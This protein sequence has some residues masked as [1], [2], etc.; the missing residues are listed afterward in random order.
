MATFD[1]LVREFLLK[2]KVALHAPRWRSTAHSDYAEAAMLVASHDSR[3]MRG[4]IVLAAH[5]VRQ[6]PKYCLSLI[7]RNERVLALDV[8]PARIHRNLLPRAKVGGTHW[9]QWPAMEAVADP[10]ERPFNQWLHEFLV[11]ANVLCRFR[12]LSPPQGV[13]LDL[14]KWPRT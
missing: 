10:R 9:Q 4:R 2:D 1:E 7:F 3:L 8:N 11:R 5:K 14:S 12:V 6:P 13:Q